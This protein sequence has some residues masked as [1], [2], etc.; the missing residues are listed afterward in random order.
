LS[1]NLR[2][3]TPSIGENHHVPLVK[4]FFLRFK[5]AFYMVGIDSLFSDTPTGSHSG[6][7]DDLPVED[8]DL[9]RCH[10]FSQ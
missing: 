6:I 4:R 9:K 3:K 8:W 5:L 10:M 7:G 2:E 1:E